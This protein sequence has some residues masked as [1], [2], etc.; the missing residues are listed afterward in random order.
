M[1]DLGNA[2]K[3]VGLDIEQKTPQAFSFIKL[4]NI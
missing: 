3:Y 2:S 1:I 4:L